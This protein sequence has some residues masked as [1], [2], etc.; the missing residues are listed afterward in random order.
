MAEDY[1]FIEI[2]PVNGSPAYKVIMPMGKSIVLRLSNPHE[3]MIFETINDAKH[4]IALQQRYKEEYE[5]FTFEKMKAEQASNPDAFADAPDD[6]FPDERFAPETVIFKEEH[7]SENER[8]IR[9]IIDEVLPEKYREYFFRRYG[10]L[11]ANTE[12]ARLD[13]V[14]EKARR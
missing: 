9:S 5:D 7:P 12:I 4:S 1:S 11:L 13:G 14:T 2:E 3:K 8:H 6:S 10:D